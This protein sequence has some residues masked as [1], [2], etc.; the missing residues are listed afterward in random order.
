MMVVQ[1]FGKFLAAAIIAISGNSM[2]ASNGAP[3]SPIQHTQA[4]NSLCYEIN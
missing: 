4:M 2:L 3:Q 1:Q